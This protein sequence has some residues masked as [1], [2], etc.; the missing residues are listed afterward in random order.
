MS[1]NSYKLNAQSNQNIKQDLKIKDK[2]H[3]LNAPGFALIQS[4]VSEVFG[5]SLLHRLP[6]FQHR[7]I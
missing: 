6:E 1:Y 3:W 2:K 7:V 5:L 4:K